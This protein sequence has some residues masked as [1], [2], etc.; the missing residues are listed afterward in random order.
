MDNFPGH[1][2]LLKVAH[3]NV[4]V[5]FLL[6]NTTS[7]IQRLDQGVSSMFKTY[8]TCR[9]FRRI[10]DAMESEHELTVG[11]FWKDFNTAHCISTIKES[12]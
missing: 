11:K 4:E 12:Q 2:K 10:L 1:P 3:P 6:P 9:T 5:I 8:Y 7:L